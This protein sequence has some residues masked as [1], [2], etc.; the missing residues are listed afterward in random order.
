VLRSGFVALLATL[1]LSQP[2]SAQ[3][4]GAVEVAKSE[5]RPDSSDIVRPGVNDSVPPPLVPPA[6][7]APQVIRAL[8]EIVILNA[9]AVG[10]N[11]L[12]RDIPTARPATWWQN[13]K[14]GWE[15]DGNYISTNNIE[16][17]YGGAVYYNVARSNGLSFWGAAPV[18]VAGSLMW[19]LFGEPVPPSLNDLIVTSLSGITLGEATRRLSLIVL[20]NQAHGL[21]RVWREGL[22]LLFNPGLGLDRLSRGRTWKQGVNPAEHRPGHLTGAVAVGAKR[23][24]LSGDGSTDVAVAAFGLRYG[25]PFSGERVTPFSSFTF[26][27]ELN[28]GPTTTL[29]QL[30]TRG[31]LAALGTREGRTTRVAGLFLDFDYQWNEAYQFSEQSFGLG[32]MSR[33][34]PGNWRLESDLSA[35]LVPLM[36]SQDIYADSL[37]Q[38]AYDYGTGVGGRAFAHLQYRGTRLLSVGYRGYWAATLN[39]ASQSKF[40]QFVTAEARAPLP[41]GLSAGA[42]YT[43][44]VQSSNYA[45]RADLTT[46]L[47]SFS[48]FLS[49]SSR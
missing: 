43:L 44:Y 6:A 42:A 5:A 24:A 37:V 13:I 12:A 26:T 29:T 1:A 31:M 20:D 23:M 2:M 28:S 41:F 39:G 38:R 4:A 9:A 33:T 40:V 48:I 25:D 36:A 45:S 8:G 47:P 49:T 34:G 27:A 32:V 7:P 16:H 15:W 46:A 22:V 14:G 10:I 21:D 35:E 18:T 11:N 3:V 19:E 30:G 17:P